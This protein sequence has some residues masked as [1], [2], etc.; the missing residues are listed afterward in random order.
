MTEEIFHKGIAKS[1]IGNLEITASSKGIRKIVFSEGPLTEQYKTNKLVE[2]CIKQLDEYFSNERNQFTIDLDI[3]GT[4]F[5]KLVWITLMT[6]PYSET[7]S[8]L[9]IAKM[10][11]DPGAVRAV[12]M[13]NNK[14]NIPILIPCHRIVG[15]K[16]DLVGYAGGLWRKEWLLKHELTNSGKEQQLDLF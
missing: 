9:E 7:A 8:Y 12:G 1:P 6:I 2:E 3:Q 14:N 5:Q 11:G 16:G 13:A 10:I 4:E 15:S